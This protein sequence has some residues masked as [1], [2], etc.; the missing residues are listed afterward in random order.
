[1]K[2]KVKKEF[3]LHSNYKAYEGD[4]LNLIT[5]NKD[6][7]DD[8][9]LVVLER[10][11]HIFPIFFDGEFEANKY[12]EFNYE[13]S[14]SVDYVWIREDE[15]NKRIEEACKKKDEQVEY[16]KSKFMKLIDKM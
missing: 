14:K 1:M 15:V 13:E 7:K 12:L 9:L 3:E 8:Y 2:V 6:F 10:F 4:I 16:W 11:N 5:I